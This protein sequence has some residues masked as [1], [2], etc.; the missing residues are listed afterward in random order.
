MRFIT[1]HVGLLAVAVAGCVGDP[2]D[3]QEREGRAVR[4][5]DG[6]VHVPFLGGA[7]V[8]HNREMPVEVEQ[9]IA[10]EPTDHPVV[11]WMA[12]L[13]TPRHQAPSGRGPNRSLH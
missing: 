11:V 8:T 12:D 7:F 4:A 5:P 10:G 6:S 3:V 13:G 9:A 2:G 1:L